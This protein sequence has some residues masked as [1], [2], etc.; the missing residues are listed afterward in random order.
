MS[1]FNISTITEE[2]SA[3]LLER[4]NEMLFQLEME[5]IQAEH[6]DNRITPTTHTGIIESFATND[7]ELTSFILTCKTGLVKCVL[8][9]VSDV[10]IQPFVKKNAVLIAEG[11]TIGDCFLVRQLTPANPVNQ[12]EDP[13]SGN[14]AAKKAFSGLSAKLQQ[15]VMDRLKNAP[16]TE[17]VDPP[18]RFFNRED[19]IAAQSTLC[20]TLPAEYQ[21]EVEALVSK[22]SGRCSNTDQ[23]TSIK[24][25]RYF[26]NIE[27]R[28]QRQPFDLPHVRS[29]LSETHY[30]M[31]K[32][33]LQ[34]MRALAAYNVGSCHTGIRLHLTGAPGTGKS[35]IARSLARAL[36]LPCCYISLNGVDDSITI[37]GSSRNYDNGDCGR[38]VK[39]F[40]RIGSTHCVMVLDEIDKMDAIN[41]SKG[42]DVG[43]ALLDLLDDSGF[44]T[45]QFMELPI[46]VSNVIFIATSN[47]ASRVP[48]TL[49]DR[50]L[51]IEVP[52][53]SREEK[54]H[55]ARN[56]I[57]PKY[58]MELGLSDHIRFDKTAFHILV[59]SYG[60]NCGLRDID[61]ALRTVCNDTILTH[62]DTVRS[63]S[64]RITAKTV[65]NVLGAAPPARG[66]FPE[67]IQPGLVRALAVSGNTGLSFPVEASLTKESSGMVITGLP[68]DV[69]TDSCRL[70]LANVRR[71]I[72]AATK[73]DLHVHFGEGAVRKDGPSAGVSIFMAILSAVTGQTVPAD[74]AFTGEIDLFGNVFAVGG[75]PEKYEAAKRSGCTRMYIPTS[76]LEQALSE[77]DPNDQ[78]VELIPVRRLDELVDAFFNLE[79]SCDQHT[80]TN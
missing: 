23:T 37:H 1:D 6:P 66:N 58:V 76:C 25:L 51:E 32:V 77:K 4:I 79:T 57:A 50:M 70:A 65:E 29:V 30:G 40:Y 41:R 19:L 47:D 45:D 11:V 14:P 8:S 55:I 56:Y 63:G 27:W 49:R 74:V 59:D 72:P 80:A 75:I 31:E 43:T 71:Y 44:F 20:S 12:E 22:L 24:A 60:L 28:K 68:S 5:A 48:H 53:Y 73:S 9:S 2:S 52:S 35:S 26:M 21:T 3:G 54:I 42:S 16:T 15:T 7:D 10:N 78:S 62:Y 64:V 36:G 69:V 46:D 33:K 61:K 34:I 18:A 38:I 17:L 67:K 13:L 39:E